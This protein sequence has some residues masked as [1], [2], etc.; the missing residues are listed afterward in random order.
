[1]IASLVKVQARRTERLSIGGHRRLRLAIENTCVRGCLLM[2]GSRQ[3]ESQICP[4]YSSLS[5]RKISFMSYNSSKKI[6]T[7]T[8]T[9]DICAKF[10][11]CR[12]MLPLQ[13][14]LS[15][16]ILNIWISNFRYAWLYATYNF[17][18]KLTRAEVVPSWKLRINKLPDCASLW[19]LR[20]RCWYAY[21]PL[22]FLFIWCNFFTNL[23]FVLPRFEVFSATFLA[24]RCKGYYRNL[25]S[26]HP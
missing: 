17:G 11:P 13:W 18:Y 15:R 24:D 4:P 1:M 9:Q 26:P 7:C 10:N 25:V 23:C 14:H 6:K 12:I 20:V 19:L 22:H 21:L 16:R 3:H 8:T 2:G 5:L